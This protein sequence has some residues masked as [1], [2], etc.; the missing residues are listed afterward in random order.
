[1]PVN[2]LQTF[3]KEKKFKASNG[4][5]KTMKIGLYGIYGTY[6]FGC[7]AIV[8]GSVEFL[9]NCSPDCKII[10][11]SYSYE[12]DCEHLK[13]LDIEIHKVQFNRNVLKRILNK[14][15]RKLG[16]PNQFL[17]IDYRK[18]LSEVDMILSI[19][20]DIYTI[21]AYLRA[22][23][24]YP[25]YNSLVKFCEKALKCGKQVVVYGASVGPFGAYRPAVE[26]YRKN[27]ASYTQIL[28]RETKSVEY[29]NSIGVHNTRFLPDPAFLVHGDQEKMV[30]RYVGI[31]LSPLSFNEIYGAYSDKMIVD[32]SRLITNL[33]EAVGTDLLLIPHV[34]SKDPKDNDALFLQKIY[35][36]LDEE[37]RKHVVF[38]N[39]KDGF[40]GVKRQ[41]RSCKFVIAARMHCAVN[42]IVE[43][44]PALFLAY[45]QKSWGMCQYVYGE[46]R[47]VLD[48]E[49]INQELVPKALEMYNEL[50]KLVEKISVKNRSIVAQYEYF[51]K[52]TKWR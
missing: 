21:P 41:I 36:N 17:M 9:K 46:D 20:G 52:E 22:R 13:D 25:Y 34:L 1:M 40:L 8:R 32:L 29:L 30:K 14:G 10:Y 19:G 38:A 26:Y 42:A 24:K 51:Y 37:T 15:Q 3:W 7:E 35:N 5:E 33:F 48:I 11:F 45:S 31:N 2:G 28:C 49:K 23:K 47:W 39:T 27:L 12:Y 4:R 44:I 50:P 43:N 18:M 6:N 16:I